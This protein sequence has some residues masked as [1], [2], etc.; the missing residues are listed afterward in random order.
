M[1]DWELINIFP[2]SQFNKTILLYSD[3]I[4]HQKS[5]DEKW[6]QYYYDGK[7]FGIKPMI[8]SD[9][10]QFP[11]IITIKFIIWGKTYENEWNTTEPNEY[12]VINYDDHDIPELLVSSLIILE[13]DY[14]N[15][16]YNIF[17]NNDNN[18]DDDN[19]NN[20]NNN[21]KLINRIYTNDPNNIKQSLINY[22]EYHKTNYDI[23]N[24]KIIIE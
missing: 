21:N 16:L 23:K 4:S 13:Y 11:R 9:D 22:N 24:V 5:Y 2:S 19:D 20:D 14:Q 8:Q 18:N 6:F 12:Y 17:D 7:S 3:G 1:E 15:K 10:L